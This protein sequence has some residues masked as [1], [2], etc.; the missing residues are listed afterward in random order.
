MDPE[1][2][3]R[4]VIPLRVILP[5]EH[6]H[7]NDKDD[8][9]GPF[10]KYN[11][12]VLKSDDETYHEH[13]NTDPG[14]IVNIYKEETSPTTTDP[15]TQDTEAITETAITSTDDDSFS[16]PTWLSLTAMSSNLIN[17]FTASSS[18]W[19]SND[20]ES[21]ITTTTEPS[22]LYVNNA[23]EKYKVRKKYRF[24]NLPQLNF[25]ELEIDREK[26]KTFITS[27]G[28]TSAATSSEEEEPN[29]ARLIDEHYNHM[30]QWLDF[31]L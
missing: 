25:D 19:H 4:F 26:V 8:P 6:I 21:P 11:Y 30:I 23:E 22:P 18:P 3:S 15:S 10:V 20:L 17:S 9:D 13:L 27:I 1:D 2:D 31:N 28:D 7:N 16:G 5:V 29:I 24:L 12:Y 14:E